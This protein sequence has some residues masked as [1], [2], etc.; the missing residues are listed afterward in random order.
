[1]QSITCE[2]TSRA[3]TQTGE[4]LLPIISFP[5]LQG[6][7]GGLAIQ[8]SACT[9]EQTAADTN[10]LSGNVSTGAATFSFIQVCLLKHT[11][12]WSLSPAATHAFAWSGS[13]HVQH[14]CQ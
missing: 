3:T 13:L 2:K 5:M 8:F 1:M 9:D 12:C 4:V 14:G 11:G 6:T 10:Q 7:A